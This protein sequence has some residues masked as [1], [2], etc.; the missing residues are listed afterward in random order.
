MALAP[1][2]DSSYE[3][4]ASARA[5]A[6]LSAVRWALAATSSSLVRASV[7]A[8]ACCEVPA[9]RPCEPCAICMEA[10]FT[11]EAP[12]AT[13]SMPLRTLLTA[14]FTA[15]LRR[16]WSPLNSPTTSADRSRAAIRSSE[17]VAASMGDR[18]AHSMAFTP[19]ATSRYAPSK[20]STPRRPPSCPR[21]AAAESVVTS[22]SS[23]RISPLMRI[24]LRESSSA[25][26]RGVST[27]E[28]SPWLTAMVVRCTSLRYVMTAWSARASSASSSWPS[29]SSVGPRSPTAT[30]DA[31]RDSSASGRWISRM[32]IAP[33]P[34]TTSSP[35]PASSARTVRARDASA[36]AAA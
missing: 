16:A 12:R 29:T 20:V 21:A 17:V 35:N 36:S 9:A 32:T 2:V 18:S 3:E 14:V 15:F 30:R 6:A 19:A 22:S 13:W 7:M 8:A 28:R 31:A 4:L 34:T 1:W 33:R 27:V 5:A 26:E 11:C 23:L 24:T 10:D 25:S